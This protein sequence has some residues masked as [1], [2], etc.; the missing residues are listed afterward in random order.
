MNDNKMTLAGKLTAGFAVPII[1]IILISVLVYNSLNSLVE[2][3][4]WVSH[5]HRVIGEGNRILASMVDMETGMR[6]FLVA[7]RE[8]FLEP[9][10]GGKKVFEE[11]I[12]QLKMTVSDNPAQVARL[13]EIE[14]LKADWLRNAAEPQIAKRREVNESNEAINEFKRISARTVGKQMFDGFRESVAILKRAY[15]R[16]SD[17]DGMILVENLLLAM[18]DQET[19]QRGFLLSGQE[20]SLEP[21]KK[22]RQNFNEAASKLRSYVNSS[23][24]RQALEDAVTKAEGWRAQ[25]AEPEIEAR[26]AMN[27]VPATLD[28]VIG[29]IEKG[30]GKKSMDAIRVQISAFVAEE[31]KLVEIR[32]ADAEALSSSTTFLTIVGTLIAIIVASIIGFIVI[33][34]IRAQIGA[35]PEVMAG[36][37]RRVSE[38]DLTVHVDSTGRE[39][40]VYAAMGAMV[41]NLKNIVE[42]VVSAANFINAAAGEVA[43]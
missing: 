32:T 29:I 7:G 15:E 43:D 24:L 41:N 42:Q 39:V 16:T 20:A 27:R 11:T 2:S 8:E 4:G 22:G 1:A 33:R 9:Y 5:T 23:T 14:K 36:I 40:G 34:G 17:K 31:E 21:Y 12:S 38:G 13:V 25:A 26:R 30:A 6:G 37:S 18:V 3:N 35:E 28:D 10:H 19:G